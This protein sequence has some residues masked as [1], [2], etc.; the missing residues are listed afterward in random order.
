M[1]IAKCQFITHK[2]K[3]KLKVQA[4]HR[5]S[6]DAGIGS[7]RGLSNPPGG[8]ALYSPVYIVKKNTYLLLV[9]TVV[10]PVPPRLLLEFLLLFL[11]LWQKDGF[12]W[13]TV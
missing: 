7:P 11:V 6:A 9:V 5:S 13:S 3:E 10:P 8:G 4:R 1:A 2:K 12:F